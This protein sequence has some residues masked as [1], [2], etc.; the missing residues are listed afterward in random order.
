MGNNGS[1]VT[2]SLLYD[3][4][5]TL[6]LY[7]C[8]TIPKIPNLNN[9]QD[10]K[11]LDDAHVGEGSLKTYFLRRNCR[12][13]RRADEA[14]RKITAEAVWMDVQ[15]CP[16]SVTSSVRDFYLICFDAGWM[17]RLSRSRYFFHQEERRVVK[18]ILLQAAMR[19]RGVQ[20]CG[21]LWQVL[22]K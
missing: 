5:H 13:E 17:Q 18:F 16:I 4:V 21:C 9:E 11:T 2:K 12:G 10:Q 8:T 22:C 14:G 6:L 3:T 19:R 1:K 7:K 15:I 20:G